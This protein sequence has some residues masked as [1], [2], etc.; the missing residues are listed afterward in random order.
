MFTTNTVALV[1]FMCTKKGGQMTYPIFTSVDWHIYSSR[2]SHCP[3][4]PISSFP[5]QLAYESHLPVLCL[6]IK[7][8][9]YDSNMSINTYTFQ[10]IHAWQNSLWI[11]HT[12]YPCP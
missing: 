11:S 9:F 8:P 1:D 7:W 12:N 4:N 5:H 3:I 6:V 10:L 2:A